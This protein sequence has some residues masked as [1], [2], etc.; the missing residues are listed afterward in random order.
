LEKFMYTGKLAQ[1]MWNKI[2]VWKYNRRNKIY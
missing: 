2:Y 1:E